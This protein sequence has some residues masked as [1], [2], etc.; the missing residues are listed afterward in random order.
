MLMWWNLYFCE[1]T[2]EPDKTHTLFARSRPLHSRLD[3]QTHATG[4]AERSWFVGP[5]AVLQAAVR[6]KTSHPREPGDVPSAAPSLARSSI[7]QFQARERVSLALSIRLAESPRLTLALAVHVAP[8]SKVLSTSSS[9]RSFELGW[10]VAES[11]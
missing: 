11:D 10:S 3:K 7:Y 5:E 1:N 4:G 2:K 6:A 8:C 9:S